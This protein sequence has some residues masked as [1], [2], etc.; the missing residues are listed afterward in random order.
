MEKLAAISN[1]KRLYYRNTLK[2]GFAVFL[3]FVSSQLKAQQ[4]TTHKLKEVN[5]N[6]LT[7]PKV[8]TIVPVQQISSADFSHYAALSV[9][10]IAANFAGVNVKDYGGIGGLKAISVRSMGATHTGVQYDGIILNDAQNGQID[11][12]KFSLYNVQSVTLYNG[13]APNIVQPARS[14]A[15][16]SILDIK[17]TRPLLPVDKPYKISIGGNAGSFGLINP[18]LQWQQRISKQWSFVLNGNYTYANGQY[19]YK[20]TGDGSDTLATRKNS[21]IKALQTDGALY[22]AKS[23]SN[24]FKVQFNYYNSDRGLPGPVIYYTATSNQRLQNHDLLVQSAYEYTA[25]SSFHL[26]IN[27]KYSQNYLHYTDPDFL[28]NVGGINERYTQ[29][30]F[31]QS[32]SVGYHLVKN[33][34]ISY[35]SDASL[36]NL[37]SD[38]YTNYYQYAFPSR[39][40]LFNVLAT[41]FTL[42]RWHFQGNLLNTYIA[43][44]VKNG[45]AANPKSAFTPTISASFQPFANSGFQ[46]R[47]FYKDIFRNPTFAEQYY[48]AIR[49]RTLNPERT[50]QYDLGVTYQKNF[51]GFWH[52]IAITADGYYNNVHNKIIYVPARSPETPS[53]I[54]LGKV[55]IKGLDVTVKTDVVPG[56]NWLGT[57]SA[58]YTY[59][60]AL[61][62]TDPG[63]S[64]YKNQIP[65]TPKSLVNLNAGVSYKNLG[66]YYNGTFSSSRYYVS[67]NTPQYYLPVYTVSNASLVYKFLA[68]KL[69]ANA[70]FEVNN[71]FNERYVVVYSYPMPG[72]SYRLSFQITI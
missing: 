67:N 18:F 31:Y 22:W 57:L 45:T 34:E 48:Y 10:D 21:D 8:Q 55:D 59:Q 39:L 65:Y 13:Q 11:L 47:A 14:F 44:H 32:V 58:N 52:D 56:V 46:L 28:N 1:I 5:I 2:I 24:K 50:K 43:D 72:R 51:D 69:P 60:Q 9:A 62:V 68:G 30:E 15:S 37:F 27:S 26:L 71:L 64:F 63:D 25:P 54:N 33:W 49:P 70:S 40:S 36:T 23:D 42:N 38:V 7:I 35:S 6:S 66:L 17:T 16:A 12:G 29:H 20:E 3:V 19:K 53:A 41:D 4:D 61:D